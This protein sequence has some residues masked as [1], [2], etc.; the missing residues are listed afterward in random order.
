VRI[1]WLKE[2]RH[3]PCAAACPRSG[4]VASKVP[5]LV[6]EAFAL[7]FSI[8]AVLFSE[9]GE[10]TARVLRNTLIG[11]KFSIPIFCTTVV[12]L[13]DADT[14]SHKVSQPWSSRVVFPLTIFP[15]PHLRC[16][17][18]I[19]VLAG[20]Q[21]PGNVEPYF[22]LHPHSANCAV[23]SP[24]DKRHWKSLRAKIAPCLGWNGLPCHS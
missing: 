4:A 13:K 20:V 9:S 11:L 15:A 19:L 7:R 8:R 14:N 16:S 23:A 22:E 18:L 6:E 17:S 24:Q 3:G 2:F 12:S 10:L 1:D 21:D 5:R